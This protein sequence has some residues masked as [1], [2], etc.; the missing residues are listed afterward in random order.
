MTVYAT[1]VEVNTHAD[2]RIKEL[3]GAISDAQ[4][5]WALFKDAIPEL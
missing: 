5:L 1:F 4:E 2:S 3:T